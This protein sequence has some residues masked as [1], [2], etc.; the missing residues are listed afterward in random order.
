MAPFQMVVSGIVTIVVY[1][2]ILAGVFKLFQIAT[3]LSEIKDLLLD[4]K[5]NTQDLDF[6]DA[7]PTALAPT[8]SPANLSLAFEAE[9]E[10]GPPSV[11]AGVNP[12]I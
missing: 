5:H 9:P 7:I 12:E 6:P 8:Q 3:S 10:Q 4:I 2:L 11:P 1:S